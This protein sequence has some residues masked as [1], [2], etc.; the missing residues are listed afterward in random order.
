[1]GKVATL[2]SLR[3]IDLSENLLTVVRTNVFRD[4]PMLALIY[5]NHNNISNIESEA[6]FN[7]T[8]LVALDVSHNV[9][10][11]VNPCRWFDNSTKIVLLLLIFNNIK[12]VEGLECMSQMN[13]LNLFANE[14]STIPS[15][16]DCVNLQLLDLGKNGISNI[17]GSEIYPAIR[18][19]QLY[20]D[21]NEML[22]LRAFS[23]SSSISII[24]LS[25]NN[26]TYIPAFCFHGLQ[27]LKTLELKNNQVF[28]IG[29]YTFPANMQNLDLYG[30]ELSELVSISQNLPKLSVL[31]IGHNNLTE[32][33]TYHPSVVNFDISDNPLKNLSLQLCTKMPN[34]QSIFLENLGIRHDDE[35]RLEL[36]GI[37]GKSCKHWHHVSLARNLISQIDEFSMLY[38]V[39]GGV[40]YSHNP[41]ESIPVLS[42]NIGIMK[43]LHFD[44]CSITNIDPMA[45]QH[46]LGLDYVTLKGN[47]IQ[48][49]P[50]MSSRRI[51]FDLRNNPIVCSCH[52]RWLHG[53]PQRSSYQF[54]KCK[55][56]VTGS[57]E[58]FDS[59]PPDRLLCRQVNCA[60]GCACFGVNISAV[61]IVNCSSKSLVAI[62]HSLP[63]EA[64][65]IYLDHNQFRKFHIPIDM[66]QMAASQLFLQNSGIFFLEQD[67]FAAFPSLKLIDLSYNELEVL[68][69]DVFH[70]LHALNSLFVHGNRI[71]QIYGGAIGYNM[72]NLQ[73]IT[74]HEN[75]LVAVPT[76][77]NYTVSSSSFNNLTLAGNPWECAACAGPILR[78]WLAQH[79]GI[80]SDI[81]DIRCNKSHLRVLDINMETS[82][83]A[84]CVNATR[85]LTYTPWG[86][87]IG[88]TVCMVLL[89][90][91]LVLA[92]CFRDHILIVLYNNLDFLKRRRRELHV[93]YDVRVIYN[94]TDER[95][96]QWI[97]GELLDV[98]ETEWGHSVFLV[99][100][101]ML[102]GG[103]H[104][105][106]IAQSIRQSRRTL[107]VVSQNF[108]DNEWVQ[109]ACQAAVQFQIENNLHRVLVA[110]W[111][112][113]DIDTMDH[114]IKVYFD[115]KQVMWKTSR[116]FW[117][118]LKSKLP[119]S[120]QNVGQNPN[121]I[122]LNWLHND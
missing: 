8:S 69:M 114:N 49:F 61:S 36:F 53:H 2:P 68:N 14:L 102:A 34:L 78:K 98:L 9:L 101:D 59:L 106:E 86:I 3:V 11:Y 19:K 60:H 111:E 33:N 16:R 39:S 84:Q 25:F 42:K 44:D 13:I 92:Y 48:Y 76:S 5:L 63:R 119:L 7:M 29:V 35:I 120:R 100:R 52:L 45:F 118:A 110:A 96:R 104:A 28:H 103:N 90:V 113:V 107:I 97:V 15:L 64:D 88:M 67:L 50:Q 105:E 37:F 56:P 83:Y 24:S 95:V 38:G 32:F 80:V 93:L 87:T 51:Q 116:G 10:F 6:F 57:S 89:L 85:T 109:F 30:N 73:I 91:S 70:S 31:V 43:Y 65:I 71:H 112:P 41:L 46:M 4:S 26:L 40:D 22:R 108:N 121:N 79:A 62:P 20:L 82:E 115:T 12:H 58:V 75:E 1:M 117:S 72:L 23:N 21:G 54:T 74:L 94:E 66:D 81:S 77:L 99:E 17:S 27:S 47:D 18:L 122:A 55:D